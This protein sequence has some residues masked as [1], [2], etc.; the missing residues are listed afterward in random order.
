[1]NMHPSTIQQTDLVGPLKR[2][3]ALL[4]LLATYGRR[5]AALT[6]ITAATGLPHPT[7]HRLLQQLLDERL[8]FRDEESRRYSLGALTFELGVAAAQQFDIREL[9]RPTLIRLAEEVGDTA[10]LVVRSGE[11][12]VCLDRQ[13]G[14]SPIRVLTLDIGSRRLLGVGA[15][16][17]AILAAL[18]ETERLS[19]I[20]EL[21]DRLVTNWKLP[22]ALLLQ[23]IADAQRAGYALI[24][25]RVTLGTCAIGRHVRDSM[26]NGI[27][28]I[29]IAAI[30]ERMDARRT[31]FVAEKVIAAA[32]EMELALRAPKAYKNSLSLSS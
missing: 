15:G 13:E 30:N 19:L 11:E 1:M 28:A 22:Q 25:N 18:P 10:Y 3:I 20:A 5:G 16:G 7:V 2:A 26:G 6:E 12:A 23:S 32:K 8:V 29:S 21:R 31:T 27:A 17:L 4:R 24:R 14:P 9:C